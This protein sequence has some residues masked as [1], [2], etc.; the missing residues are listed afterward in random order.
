MKMLPMCSNAQLPSSS[1]AAMTRGACS[2]WR[3]RLTADVAFR[4]VASV[5]FGFAGTGFTAA[6]ITIGANHR[7]HKPYNQRPKEKHL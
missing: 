4:S 6:T 7:T 5:G 2:N 1:R 3:S